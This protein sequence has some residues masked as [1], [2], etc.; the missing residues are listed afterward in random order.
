MYSLIHDSQLIL[1]PIPFNYRL[2]NG[3]LEDLE[4]DFKVTPRDYE[5]VP[6]MINENTSLVPVVQNIPSYDSRFQSVGNFEWVII[7]ENGY[8]ERV[9]MNYAINDKTLD[10]IKAEYKEQVAPIRY[11]KENQIITVTINDTE[12][13]VFTSREERDQFVIKYVSCSNE[14]EV[15]H[16][17]K[18][19]NNVWLEIGCVEIQNI[20]KEIDHIVQEAFDWEY[21]KYQEIDACTTGEE[22]YNVIL[23]EPEIVENPYDYST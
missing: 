11:E 21:S 9:E 19:N 6:L 14:P 4:I 8:P 3:E 20:L 15:T 16:K 17:Y 18:F 7:D 5:K 13:E 1:G 23:R 22:V 12:V 10:Q 2:I